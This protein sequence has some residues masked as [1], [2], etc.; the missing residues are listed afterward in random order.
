VYERE[1]VL[2]VSFEGETS[3]RNKVDFVVED[4]I[5]IEVKAAPSFTKENYR[6]AKRYLVSSNKSLCLLVNFGIN[7]CIIQRV[8]NPN[9]VIRRSG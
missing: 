7:Y 1:K 9:T 2:G 8:L 3:G 6:Q 5:V 4:K